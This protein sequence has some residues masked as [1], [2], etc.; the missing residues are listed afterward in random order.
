MKDE[1]GYYSFPRSTRKIF[2]KVQDGDT[3]I[4]LKRQ[5]NVDGM[6]KAAGVEEYGY[7]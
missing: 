2:K 3:D 7:L 5:N 4:V 6:A 1:E